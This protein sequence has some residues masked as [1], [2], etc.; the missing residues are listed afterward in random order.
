MG[1]FRSTASW[2]IDL[3]GENHQEW[4]HVRLH[5]TGKNASGQTHY[6]SL[7][8]FE[9]YGTVTGVCDDIGKSDFILPTSPKTVLVY[10]TSLFISSLYLV[11][12]AINPSFCHFKIGFCN[13]EHSLV[14]S[15]KHFKGDFFLYIS[16]G[17]RTFQFFK[18]IWNHSKQ[19]F[20]II[21]SLL[22]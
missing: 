2:P 14:T 4:R 18:D 8:G 12:S 21:E 1:L 10:N 3:H 5:Q 11:F 19:R 17:W 9:I 7:S 16:A 6:V 20:K 13:N 15:F 22:R